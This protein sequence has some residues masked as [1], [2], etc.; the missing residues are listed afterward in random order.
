MFRHVM[1]HCGGLCN[2]H[3][4]PSGAESRGELWS[5]ACMVMSST[6]VVDEGSSANKTVLIVTGGVD[7]KLYM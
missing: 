5:V 3:F 2:I 1:L 7:Q 4:I 6:T